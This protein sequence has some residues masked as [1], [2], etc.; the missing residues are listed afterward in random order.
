VAEY[1]PA[2]KPGLSAAGFMIANGWYH[3]RWELKVYPVPRET[4]HTAKRLLIERGLPALA[5]WLRG[6]ESVA[7]RF[8]VQRAELVFNPIEDMLTMTE[9]SRREGDKV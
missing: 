1:H 5:L 2:R 7:R 8:T 4:R 9:T 6:T 3:E